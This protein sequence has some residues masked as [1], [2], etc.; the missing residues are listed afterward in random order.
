M[1]L[2][3]SGKNSFAID[4]DFFNASG[5]KAAKVMTVHVPVDPKSGKSMKIPEKLFKILQ[6][7]NKLIRHFFKKNLFVGLIIFYI[8]AYQIICPFFITFPVRF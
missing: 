8:T 7:L 3:S 4:Y 2:N 6:R 5:E 1:S